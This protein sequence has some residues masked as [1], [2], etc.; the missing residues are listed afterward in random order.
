MQYLLY[1]LNDVGFTFSP[2]EKTLTVLN[3]LLNKF[4]TSQMFN[5]IWRSV[6]DASAFY[7]SKNV[8]K[9]HAANVAISSI[10][11]YG[12]KAIA[13]G[14]IIKGYQREFNLLQTSVSEV[15]YNRVLQIGRL[16]FESPPSIDFIESKLNELIQLATPEQNKSKE[17]EEKKKK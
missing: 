6:K 12:E 16:G 7:L 9:R 4:S 2:G 5:L 13:D 15:L 8:N 3:D 17:K 10:Q 11:K 14:W 1:K